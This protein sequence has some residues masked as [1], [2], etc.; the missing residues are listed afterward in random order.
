MGSTNQAGIKASVGKGGHNDLWDVMTVQTLLNKFIV[1]GCLQPLCP[2]A[3]DGRAGPKTCKAIEEFQCEYLG[4]SDPDG[5][6]DPGGPTLARL[7]GGLAPKAPAPTVS[8]D[9][10]IIIK[11]HKTTLVP[12]GVAPGQIKVLRGSKVIRTYPAW[13]GGR[14][15]PLGEKTIIKWAW[16]AVSFRDDYVPDCWFSYGA[17]FK[18]WPK[19]GAE[20]VLVKN[21]RTWEVRRRSDDLGEIFYDG[22]W[23]PVWKNSNPFG[24]VMA[25]LFPGIVELHGTGK[26]ETGADA[27]PEVTHGCVRT[28][29]RNI[30]A[31]MHLAPPGT[32]VTT[33]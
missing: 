18:G 4:F 1:A 24:V 8:G 2:L 27:F 3:P 21:G 19:P 10:R 12:G 6:V 33:E 28:Y 7:M 22:D 29:N 5:R 25:D 16:G 20:G 32:K 23:Y 31:I 13:H 9:V 14:T 15:T 30:L 17:T 26:D 11:R